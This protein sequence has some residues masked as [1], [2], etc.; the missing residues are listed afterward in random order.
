MS[1][2]GLKRVQAFFFANSLGHEPVRSWLAELDRPDRKLI[3]RALMTVE[4]GWPVGMPISRPMGG[5]LH[6]LRVTLG[7][8]R[9][10]RVFFY[11]DRA[12]RLILLHAMLK[13]TRATPERDLELARR[14]MREHQRSIG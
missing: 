1:G 14:R 9:A 4:F 7:N 13:T 12:E 11:I 8:Q 6:E 3:G 2:T 5:G 10:A